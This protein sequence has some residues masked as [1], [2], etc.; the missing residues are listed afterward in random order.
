MEFQSFLQMSRRSDWWQT[1][2]VVYCTCSQYP[3]LFFSMLVDQLKKLNVPNVQII[4]LSEVQVDNINAQLSSSFLGNRTIYWLKNIADLDAKRRAYWFSYVQSYQ[5]PNCLLVCNDKYISSRSAHNLYSCDIPVDLEQSL[6]NDVL[7]FMHCTNARANAILIRN[8]FKSRKKIALDTL[9]LLTHYAKVAEMDLDLFLN[10][11]LDLI[12]VPDSSLFDL[13]KHFFARKPEQFFKVWYQVSNLYGEM[14]WIAYWSDI[15]WR[16]YHFARLSQMGNQTDAKKIG[17]RL[18]FSFVQGGWRQVA[19]NELKNAHNYM[20]ALDR[21][22]KNGIQGL[23]L[24]EL[25]YLK[26]FLLKF[27]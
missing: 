16:A 14:F 11:W 17:I 20:C 6:C 22:F 2:S 26:F 1:R 15:L 12:V 7:S 4:D 21:D 24:I 27:D 23:Q 13:S 10:Q 3:V 18:P 19:L 25:L 5:G 9:C 8:I